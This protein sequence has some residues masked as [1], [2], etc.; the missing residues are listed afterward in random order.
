MAFFPIPIAGPATVAPL[1]PVLAVLLSIAALRLWLLHRQ[2]AVLQAQAQPYA[3][4]LVTQRV[5]SQLWQQAFA[6]LLFAAITFGAAPQTASG[7]ALTVVLAA[8]WQ[9]PA[10][11]AKPFGLDARHGLNRLS[12]LTFLR[13][14]GLRLLLSALVAWPAAALALA[15]LARFGEP[16]WLAIWLLGWV[17]WI[18]QHDG[19]PKLAARLFETV[20]PLPEGELRQRLVALLVRCGVRQPQLY[21]LQASARSVQANAQVSGTARAPR[22]VLGDTLIALLS[23]A[24]IEAVVAHELGHVQRG[25]LRAQRGLIGLCAAL[26]V[27]AAAVLT[28]G[29]APPPARLALAWALLPSLWFLVLPWI[30]GRYRRYEFEADAAAA[31]RASGAALAQA[32]RRLT[33]NNR[34]APDADRWYERV[35]HTHPATA[36]RLARLDRAG[37]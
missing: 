23:P 30:N 2:R 20:E 16:A 34:N 14:Q 36:E 22:I 31:E 5:G 17:G 26:V 4:G 11:A 24:E 10:L 19:Q 15:L 1:L 28:A 13:D 8:L 21:R 32:L 6:L 27:A 35:Y 25:H 18:V 29:I 33:A 3:L 9:W 12:G 37:T 7:L